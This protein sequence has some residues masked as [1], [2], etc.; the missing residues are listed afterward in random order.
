M[1]IIHESRVPH[2]DH[3]RIDQI[4]VGAIHELPVPRVPRKELAFFLL[5]VPPSF[6]TVGELQTS[7]M[8]TQVG[9]GAENQGLSPAWASV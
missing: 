2:V 6:P 7:R 9:E 1:R 4:P 5:P 3:G 8:L